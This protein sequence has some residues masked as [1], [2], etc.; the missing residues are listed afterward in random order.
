MRKRRTLDEIADEA[1]EVIDPPAEIKDGCRALVMD[2]L[3]KISR[4][5][6]STLRTRPI[7][8]SMEGYA[9]ALRAVRTKAVAAHAFHLL[10]RYCVFDEHGDGVS[11][12][13]DLL[14]DELKE[15]K[16]L[17]D[18]A[19]DMANNS[20]KP[21]GHPLPDERA[22]G[23][24]LAAGDLIGGDWPWR[25]KPTLT[26]GGP[27]LRLSSLLYEAN[28]GEVDRDL[29]RYCRKLMRGRRTMPTRTRVVETTA[30][31]PDGTSQDITDL[32]EWLRRAKDARLLQTRR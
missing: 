15:V 14:D 17:C 26:A 31:Y 7:I 24:A 16:R 12:F 21:K 29:S 27:W 22:R 3:E 18:F 19:R 20:P 30:Y 4:T 1:V 6:F 10:P 23:A 13:I 8:I 5:H 28:T 2:R 32:D 9:K 11:S 25:R